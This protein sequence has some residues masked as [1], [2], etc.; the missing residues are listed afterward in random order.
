[1]SSSAGDDRDSRQRGIIYAGASP[2]RHRRQQNTGSALS[3]PNWFD[4][5]LLLPE[6]HPVAARVQRAL[7]RSDDQLQPQPQ[8]LEQVPRMSRLSPVKH[9]LQHK[10]IA[11]T[12]SIEAVHT[13][14]FRV[15]SGGGGAS[16]TSSRSRVLQKRHAT[17]SGAPVV[18]D[19]L[20]RKSRLKEKIW[21]DLNRFGLWYVPSDLGVDGAVGVD[22]LERTAD[23]ILQQWEDATAVGSVS[24]SQKRRDDSEDERALGFKAERGNSFDQGPERVLSTTRT[25]TSAPTPALFLTALPGAS[26]SSQNLLMPG[27]DVGPEQDDE[28]SGSGDTNDVDD[29]E[30]EDAS[31]ATS[32]S[33]RDE[34]RPPGMKRRQRLKELHAFVEKQL[35]KRLFKSWETIE[36][37]FTGSGDLTVSQ[38]LKFLQYSDVQ[39]SAADA[40][41]VQAI[42]EKHVRDRAKDDLSAVSETSAGPEEQGTSATVRLPNA[43]PKVAA[44]SFDAFRRIFHTTDKLEAVKWKRE[45][46]REKIRQRHEKEIYE[47]E[48]AALE[49]RGG[50]GPSGCGWGHEERP[51]DR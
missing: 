38:I 33:R 12:T 10:A 13:R 8:S 31:G 47:K 17:R 21:H 1:M 15:Y 3:V 32:G 14:P 39:L 36:I 2:T 24:T 23:A 22:S 50:V 46:D 7:S 27:N 28:G 26:E 51:A 18:L 35:Q 19:R 48:L 41:K 42:L 25:P 6:P 43:K 9:L 49:E 30:E 20:D 16:S 34:I 45:F 5:P 11:H 29:E 37:A 4:L 40:A 44:L